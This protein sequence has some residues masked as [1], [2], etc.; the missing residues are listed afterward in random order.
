MPLRH[1]LFYWRSLRR[2]GVQADGQNKVKLSRAYA[3]SA[4]EVQYVLRIIYVGDPLPIL[5][6]C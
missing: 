2:P 6:L 3:E 1:F 4:H 5:Y